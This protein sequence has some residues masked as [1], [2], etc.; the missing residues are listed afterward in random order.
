VRAILGLLV[1]SFDQ[2]DSTE[3]SYA[4]VWFLLWLVACAIP[5]TGAHASPYTPRRAWGTNQVV[6]NLGFLALGF[7][8]RCLCAV[9]DLLCLI[10]G[11]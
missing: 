11:G 7:G 10:T 3:L 1:R 2:L 9:L 4:L 6:C 8:L 5:S